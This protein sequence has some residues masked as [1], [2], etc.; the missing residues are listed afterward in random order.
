MDRRRL[1]DYNGSMNR[2]T[3]STI[4][5]GSLCA[6]LALAACESKQEASET[7]TTAAAVESS[8]K[9]VAKTETADKKAEPAKATKPAGGKVEVSK[10]GTKF[11]PPVKTEQIPDGAWMCDMGTVHYARLDKGDGKCPLCKM[12]LVQKGAKAEK[13]A[14]G[15]GGSHDGHEH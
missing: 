7:S 8:E 1:S 15:A 5:L 10:E 13:S 4:V 12:D 6:L 14:Q 3:S 9:P 11:D 2:C